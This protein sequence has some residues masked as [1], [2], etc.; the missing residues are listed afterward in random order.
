MKSIPAKFVTGF[1]LIELMITLVISLVAMLMVVNIYSST[2]QSHVQNDRIGEALEYGRYAMSLLA[3]DLET[4]GFMG[5]IMLTTPTLPALPNI[6]TDTGLTVATDCGKPADTNWVYDMSNYLQ[7][8]YQASAATVA[9]EHQCITSGEY[10]NGTNV[11]SV[12]RVFG[13][14]D[15]SALVNNAV[16]LRSDRATGCLWYYNTSQTVPADTSLCPA[17]GFDEW[18][19]LVNIYFIRPYAKTVGDN[20]PTLCKKVLGATSSGT[21]Q[22]DMQTVCL[23]EGIEQFHIEYGIDTDADA[24]ARPNQFIEN[25]TSTQLKKAVTAR[26]Y[27]LA[28]ARVEDAAFANNKTYNLGSV[29][30][31]KNDNYYRRVY[32]TTVM[33]RNTAGL[34]TW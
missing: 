6:K 10:A 32:S 7:Y 22:A 28:R 27:V 24:D 8:L 23:A 19:Y 33:L 21:L 16:Y 29:V 4:A 20:I 12:K 13:N 17:S 2:R 31:T 11:L 18:R 26:I 9:A 34:A 3:T 1:S 30:L 15:T 14:K 5:G 25:P